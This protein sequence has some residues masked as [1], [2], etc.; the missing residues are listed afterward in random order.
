ML[1][2]IFSL[3]VRVVFFGL[4]LYLAV[5]FIILP[6]AVKWGI[7]SQGSKFLKHPVHVR[8]VFINPVM[9]SLSIN[10]LEIQGADKQLIAG[11]KKFNADVSFL[12]LLQKA[13]RVESCV[14][15]GLQVNV[16]LLSGGR[17]N[18]MELIPSPAGQAAEAPVEVKPSVAQPPQPAEIP[19]VVVDTV[20]VRHG[21]IHFTDE[22]VT[23]RFETTLGDIDVQVTGL[24]T[25]PRGQAKVVFGAKLDEKGLISVESLVKPFV[26]PLELETAFTLDSYALTVLSPYVGKYTGNA[27]E[28][29][30]FDLRMDYRISGNKLTASHK[31][32]VQKFKFGEKVESKDALKLPF[33]LALALLEDASGQIKISLPVTGDMSDP[34]FRYW[35]LVGQVVR[36]FFFKVVTKP[37][38]FLGSMLGSED[39]TDELGYVR[40]SPGKADLSDAEKEKLGIVVRGLKE[41]PKLRLEIA[42]SYDPD[43]D[44]KAM[45]TE[46]FQKDYEKLRRESARDERKI[47]EQ[48]YQRSFGVRDLWLLTNKFKRPDGG[49]DESKVIAEIKRQLIENAPADKTAMDALASARAK[50]VYDAIIA[51]GFD[52]QKTGLGINHVAQG[53]MGY[54]PLDF[55]L[56]VFEEPAK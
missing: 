9:L 54:V 27:L 50:V 17:I 36:N 29:G 44:W 46:T 19:L 2:R 1:K 25:D 28:D 55:T 35:P 53:S 34:E 15:D 21:S 39:G 5:G 20:S 45:Q 6:F 33:G 3:I 16:R 13:Y 43:M 18:V 47:Y 38:S 10:G 22:T 51:L 31:I 37:F 56:T 30:K 24:T 42:G 4:V 8:S 7:E 14:L 32:L 11:F 48:L 41:H 49:Y 26:Q 40:F 23:P 12:A 52:A